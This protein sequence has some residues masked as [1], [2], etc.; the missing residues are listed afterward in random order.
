MRAV[1]IG[2]AV[3]LG[4]V[5]LAHAGG[6]DRYN[7]KYLVTGVKHMASA[8]KG[9]NIAPQFNP[10]EISVD[11]SVPWQRRQKDTSRYMKS[12]SPHLFD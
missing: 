6:N 12:K 5:G 8:N 2:A 11:Q 10:K 7:G 1:L 9:K 3:C 4:A